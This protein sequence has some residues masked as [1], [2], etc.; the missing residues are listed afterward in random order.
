LPNRHL[1]VTD[2]D[3]PYRQRRS[4]GLSP[5]SLGGC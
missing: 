1:D 4:F 5:K 3:E 2:S